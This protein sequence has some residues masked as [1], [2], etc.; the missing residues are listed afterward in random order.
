MARLHA[1]VLAGLSLVLAVGCTKAAE[2]NIS[3][4]SYRAFKRLSG[5]T[6][7]GV[8]KLKY[9]ELLQEASAELLI[10]A[11][12]APGSADT[13]AL[14]RYV[15]ALEKYKDAGVLWAEQIDGAQYDWIPKGRIYLE[16]EAAAIAE[17]YNLPTEAH[18]TRF[19]SSFRS[20]ASTSI[21]VLW[22]LAKA[23]AVGADSLVIPSIRARRL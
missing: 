17:R 1:C 11:D 4:A 23:D 7:V 12:L 20:V 15:A 21:Q 9:D 10:L 14:E 13:A 6:A 5:A 16:P 22:E 19:G 2:P 3:E 8:T 18:K